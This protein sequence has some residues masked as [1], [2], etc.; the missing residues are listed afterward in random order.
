MPYSIGRLYGKQLQAYRDS[1]YRLNICDGAVR[2]GKTVGFNYRWI[3]YVLAEGPPGDLLMTGKTERTLKRNILNPLQEML[4]DDFFRINQGAGECY[5]GDRKIYLAGANDERAEGKIRGLTLAGVLSDEICLYPE[6]FFQMLLSRLSIKDAKFFGT[7]NPEGPYHWL[8][9]N[10]LDRIKDLN[11]G[12][13]KFKI[14]DNRYLPPE[15]IEELKKEYTGMFYQR[16]IDG[17]WVLAEGTIYDV[18]DVDKHMG[19]VNNPTTFK[20]YLVSV[21]Y[22]TANPCTFGLYGWDEGLPAY[23]I[24]EYYHDGSDVSKPQKTD[25]EYGDDLE[26]FVGTIPLEVVYVDPSALSFI[27]ELRQRNKWLIAPAKNDVLTGIR[28]VHSCLQNGNYFVDSSCQETD[29]GY[30]SYVWD[31]NAQL[32]GEDKPLKQHDHTCDRDRYALFSH[33]YKKYFATTQT[34]WK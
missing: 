21:D 4:G 33:F 10:Y 29:K 5:L 22:G 24:R 13:W 20:H 17:K 11:L 23:L 28:F 3:N 34:L 30:S 27:T 1:N 6:N 26:E 32:R 7:T 16:F 2:S 25:K 18:W 19:R 31:P 14:G 12:R 15:Y 8:K 9:A